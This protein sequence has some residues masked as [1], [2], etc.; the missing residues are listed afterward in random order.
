MWAVMKTLSSNKVAQT[1]WVLCI[2]FSAVG[3]GEARRR[4]CVLFLAVISPTTI[5]GSSMSLTPGNQTHQ[6][7]IGFMAILTAAIQFAN[8]CRAQTSGNMSFC[9]YNTGELICC[10]SRE[11]KRTLLSRPQSWGKKDDV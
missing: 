3:Q 8:Q 2:Y 7:G 11:P 9:K 10:G 5:Y 1:F 6:A 4:R